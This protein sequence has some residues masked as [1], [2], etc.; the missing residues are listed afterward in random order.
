MRQESTQSSSG[1]NL[2]PPSGASNGIRSE[3]PS[4]GLISREANLEVDEF[5]RQH[6]Q[7]NS[8]QSLHFEELY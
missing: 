5:G 4:G 7:T 1:I 3:E 8:S 2:L 6:Q